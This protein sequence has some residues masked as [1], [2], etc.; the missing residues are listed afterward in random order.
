M[1]LL[2]LVLSIG[3]LGSMVIFPPVDKETFDKIDHNSETISHPYSVPS[4]F[5]SIFFVY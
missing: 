2:V 3:I 1:G 4:H 5:L